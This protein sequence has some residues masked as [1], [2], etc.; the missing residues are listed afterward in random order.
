[1]SRKIAIV[2]DEEAIRENYAVAFRRQ[3]Y[4]V[5]TYENRPGALQAFQERLPDLAIVDLGRGDEVE[6][7][8][9]LFLEKPLLGYGY[10]MSKFAN[11]G[12]ANFDI[13]RAVFS[14]RG[15]N[16][17]SAHLQVALDLGIVGLLLFWYFLY[18]V[19]L[20]GFSHYREGVR[21]PLH[22]AGIVFFAAFFA[23]AGDS[24]VH[25][26]AFSPG[27]SMAIVF[28][29][30]AAATVRIHLFA[31]ERAHTEEEPDEDGSHRTAD[32][33]LPVGSGR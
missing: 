15:Y 25:G 14:M 4:D 9:D 16:Y 33:E 28:Y 29:L 19:L 3:G 5:L 24:F 12:R 7:G 30:V 8:F 11:L 1:M 26:W 13:S 10:A 6:G 27:S 23:L 32:E 17:H 21:D 31:R 18:S 22:L 2:E 20:R